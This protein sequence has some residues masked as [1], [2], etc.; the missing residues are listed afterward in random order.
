[1]I[2]WRYCFRH[3]LNAR[4]VP[5]FSTTLLFL[6]SLLY[7]FRIS[8][9]YLKKINPNAFSCIRL[10]PRFLSM[11]RQY[12]TMPHAFVCGIL[13]NVLCFSRSSLIFCMC[14]SARVRDSALAPDSRSRMRS[15]TSFMFIP[16]VFIRA[17]IPTGSNNNLTSGLASG[18]C[19]S[20]ASVPT[21]SRGIL[22]VY[23]WATSPFSCYCHHSQW[24][25]QPQPGWLLRIRRAK[26]LWQPMKI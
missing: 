24:S 13:M 4:S 6:F 9:W 11:A 15:Y 21:C 7:V 23:P 22:L 1:M 19:T 18:L 25:T 2:P 26:G 16:Y 5:W 10:M 12:F 17:A 14:S 20:R 8:Y 3:P